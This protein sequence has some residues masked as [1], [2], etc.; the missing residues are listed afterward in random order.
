MKVSLYQVE[1]DRTLQGTSH[2]AWRWSEK[3]PEGIDRR[4]FPTRRQA[5]LFA[6]QYNRKITK[7]RLRPGKFARLAAQCYENQSGEE[8]D[9]DVSDV[10]VA[11]D[12]RA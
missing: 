6:G 8:E 5:V 11:A 12:E 1:S 9:Q 7:G 10:Q 2:Y 3:S 4:D